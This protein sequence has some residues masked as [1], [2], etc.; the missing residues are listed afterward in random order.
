[1]HHHGKSKFQ[2]KHRRLKVLHVLLKPKRILKRSVIAFRGCAE[3]LKLVKG[4]LNRN[5]LWSQEYCTGPDGNFFIFQRHACPPT[6]PHEL[7]ML[8]DAALTV[9]LWLVWNWH[10]GTLRGPWFTF[11]IWQWCNFSGIEALE[12]SCIYTRV[13]HAEVFLVIANTRT[14]SIQKQIKSFDVDKVES[15]KPLASKS[16][17]L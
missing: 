7:P 1:M 2:P 8:L 13:I 14:K 15:K 10:Q 4:L 3:D 16:C 6:S 11:D 9:S 17:F 12:F 5:V